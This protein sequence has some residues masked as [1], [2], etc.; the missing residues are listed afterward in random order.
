MARG[1]T[2]ASISEASPKKA[3]LI[4]H[5]FRRHYFQMVLL[6][7]MEFASLLSTSGR[8]SEA[9]KQLTDDEV[10]DKAK[11]MARRKFRAE[12]EAIQESFLR[13][14]HRYRFTGVSNQVQPSELFDKLRAS[15][16]I[17][18]LYDDVKNELQAAVVFTASVE[19]GQ[20]ARSS[21]GLTV[22]ATICAA[23]GIAF[24][25][26][27][28][29]L[30]VDPLKALFAAGA[31]LPAGTP[32]PDSQLKFGL[33]LLGVVTAV[34]LFGAALLQGWA[35]KHLAA[36]ADDRDADP[37]KSFFTRFFLWAVPIC[38]IGGMALLYWSFH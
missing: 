23:I 12:V 5:H 33:G 25:F 14:V 22:I 24:T 36:C 26:L 1:A 30:V 2:M 15:M 13:F 6:A 19:Q 21:M 37:V 8:I 32:T 17:D 29:A 38:L 9:V 31:A 7:N 28:L 10:T 35:R 3:N 34:F 4:V 27:G 20:I 11:P 18:T 16:K